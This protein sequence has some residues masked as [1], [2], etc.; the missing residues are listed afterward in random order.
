MI[1]SSSI[2][3]FCYTGSEE[4]LTNLVLIVL[5]L[6][7]LWL[8]TCAPLVFAAILTFY[9]VKVDIRDNVLHLHFHLSA[10]DVASVRCFSCEGDFCTLSRPQ[11]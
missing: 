10:A 3:R 2:V 4:F 11:S 9:R 8:K 5:L 6:L 7:F 1:K